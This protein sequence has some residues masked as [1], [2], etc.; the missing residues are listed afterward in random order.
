MKAEGSL[1]LDARAM[2]ALLRL[3]GGLVSLPAMLCNASFRFS[4]IPEFGN[5][6]SEAGGTVED[7]LEV[8][9]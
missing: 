7:R 9:G 4:G 5:R 8:K 3:A 2:Y 1:R 6:N